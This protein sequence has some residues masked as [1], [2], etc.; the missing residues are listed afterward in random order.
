MRLQYDD[1]LSGGA[2]IWNI[3]GAVQWRDIKQ[4]VNSA[5]D[6]CSNLPSSKWHN[7]GDDDDDDDDDDDK[8]I[9]RTG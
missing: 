2:W 3:N 1:D 7:V 9:S 8:D 5:S 6:W 4:R